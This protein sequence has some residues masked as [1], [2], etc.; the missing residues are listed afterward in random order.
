MNRKR[1]LSVAIML[2]GIVATFA[3]EQPKLEVRP[4]AR[5]LMDGA[6]IDAGKE[7]EDLNDGFAIPDIRIGV[8]AKY[9]DWSA[10]FEAGMQYGKVTPMDMYI[11]KELTSKD[12][13]RAGYFVTHYGLNSSYSS[14]MRT[15]MEEPRCNLAL[16]HNYMLG[17]EY[18]H[19]DSR[20]FGSLC[21]F[22]EK[23]S[24]VRSG[25]DNGNQGVGAVTRLVYLPINETGRFVAVGVSGGLQTPQYNKDNE[26]NHRMITLTS[27]YPTRVSQVAAQKAMITDA[28][29]MAE[30]TPELTVAYK[31]WCFE[32]QYYFNQVNRRNA[33]PAYQASGAYGM[34]RTVLRGGD[35][36]HNDEYCNTTIPK[37]G[38]MELCLGYSYSDLNSQKTDIR[39]GIVNDYSLCFNY[40]VNNYVIWRVRGSITT[41]RHRAGFED[42]KVSLIETRLQFKL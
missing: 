23:E 11:R 36:T 42:N 25:N 13:I 24:M 1:I 2:M 19:H 33:L 27:T 9:G 21:F 29:L 37:G 28:R 30:F 7:E 5:L 40:Y 35:Y 4:I 18:V 39:G 16:A 17:V 31:R 10:V 12:F 32:G 8:A 38:T 22:N 14:S 6:L 41:A 20:Y 3:Q 34:I 15:G 26:L